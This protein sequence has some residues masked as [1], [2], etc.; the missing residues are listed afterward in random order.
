MFFCLCWDGACFLSLSVVIFGSQES[1]VAMCHLVGNSS[2]NL[3]GVV[4]LG[5]R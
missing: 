2:G 5:S 4:I 3:I 1:V